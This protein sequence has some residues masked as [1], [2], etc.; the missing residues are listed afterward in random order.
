MP[1]SKTLAVG[2]VTVFSGIAV[3]KWEYLIIRGYVG[4][5]AYIVE[6]MVLGSSTSLDNSLLYS[7]CVLE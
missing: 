4:Y 6:H 5:I 3:L 2:T 1:G 7:L